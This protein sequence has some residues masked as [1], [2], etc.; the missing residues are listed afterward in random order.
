MK[1]YNTIIY[2]LLR[3]AVVLANNERGGRRDEQWVRDPVRRGLDDGRE[4]PSRVGQQLAEVR[5]STLLGVELVEGLSKF[6]TVSKVTET[7]SWALLTA[8]SML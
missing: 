7:Q 2:F 3:V 5:E 4:L 1:Y 8:M 6:K